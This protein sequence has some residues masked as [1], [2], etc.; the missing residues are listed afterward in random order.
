[1]STDPTPQNIS[2]LKTLTLNILKN[3]SPDTIAKDIGV[4]E[5]LR[6]DDLGL[7]DLGLDDLGLDDTG[8]GGAGLGNVGLLE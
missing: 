4:P 6:L 8:L 2:C 1:M 5:R 3:S 7:D